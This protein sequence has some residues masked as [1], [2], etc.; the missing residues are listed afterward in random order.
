[1]W[2]T[3]EA[4]IESGDVNLA[5]PITVWKT[6]TSSFNFITSFFVFWFSIFNFFISLFLEVKRSFISLSSI[7]VWRLFFVSK[8]FILWFRDSKSKLMQLPIIP[9]FL[10]NNF[11]NLSFSTWQL[12]NDCFRLWFSSLKNWILV[13]SIDILSSKFSSLNDSFSFV[14][15]KPL[16]SSSC[17]RLV[18]LSILMVICHPSWLTFLQVN[19]FDSEFGITSF[20]CLATILKL[21]FWILKLN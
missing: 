6:L 15:A 12:C 9:K 19:Y 16:V 20:K 11:C 4:R 3:Q 7:D 10:S 8:V 18:L 1:M 5:I 2:Y 14:L 13:L 17:W 21:I